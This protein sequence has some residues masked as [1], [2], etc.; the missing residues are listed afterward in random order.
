MHEIEIVSAAHDLDSDI[1]VLKEQRPFGHI[2]P[3]S[4]D[5]MIGGAMPSRLALI[6]AQPGAGKTTFVDQIKTDLASQ[7]VP[8]LIASLELDKSQLTGKSLARLSE[9]SL[10]LKDLQNANDDPSIA[11]ALEKAK[12]AY[13]SIAQNIFVINDPRTTAIQLSTA[14]GRIE[15]ELGTP[16]ALIVD[17]VQMI[18]RESNKTVEERAQIMEAIGGLR[19]IAD[20]YRIPVFAVSSIGRRFYGS[21][22][23]A[24]LE[25]LSGAQALEYTADTVIFLAPDQDAKN[26]SRMMLS[27]IRPI[28]AT[29]LKNRYGA[30]GEVDLDF[31]TDFALFTDRELSRK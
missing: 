15:K 6:G 9:G 23:S 5:A 20:E 18:Q 1:Q 7:G 24:T 26:T 28:K 30:T 17:Y 27:G 8:V 22:K 19:R 12:C 13:A 21:G 2:T 29:V 3:I 11:A 16:P 31:H 4:L 25:V 10:R 14:V